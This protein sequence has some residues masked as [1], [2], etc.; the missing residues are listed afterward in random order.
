MKKL[1]GWSLIILLAAGFCLQ[2]RT[3]AAGSFHG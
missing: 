1:L 3:A 2:K